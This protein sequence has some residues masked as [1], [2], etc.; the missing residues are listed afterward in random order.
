MEGGK[1]QKVYEDFQPTLKWASDANSHVLAID[2]PGFQKEEV[3][4]QVD[5]AAGKL[6]VRGEQGAGNTKD[7][8]S[9]KIKRF[10][11]D[12]DVP[13]HSNSEKITGRFN[14]YSSLVLTI[15]KNKGKRD[16]DVVLDKINN[17][18][19]V[20]V[21]AA[22]AFTIGFYVSRRLRSIGE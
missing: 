5:S 10:K 14:Q 15:P 4:V 7:S 17:N 6:M 1:A 19:R 11:L 3:Y 20:I 13:E 18:R 22:A 2:V 9:E 21:I 8:N 12:L 16:I